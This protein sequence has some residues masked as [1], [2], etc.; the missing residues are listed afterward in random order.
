MFDND[1]LNV[2][3]SKSDQSSVDILIPENN[4]AE[5]MDT[6]QAKKRKGLT[7]IDGNIEKK[8]RG[9]PTK[10]ES[11]LCIAKENKPLYCSCNDIE[12]GKMIKCDNVDCHVVWYHIKCVGIV[13]VPKDDWFCTFCK[14]N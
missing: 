2:L 4:S 11:A 6:N 5:V 13:T 12:Y 14:V 3:M 9:R 1:N 10:A 8:K 7:I